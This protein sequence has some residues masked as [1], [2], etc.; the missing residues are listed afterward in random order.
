MFIHYL[1]DKNEVL[2]N[3]IKNG[4]NLI[5]QYNTNSNAGPNHAKIGPYSFNI[6]RERV[7]DENSPV[8]FVIPDHAVFNYPNKI[9]NADFENWI[10]ERGI[11][12][13]DNLNSS[14]V[15]PLALND[16]GES[17]QKG[18]LVIADYG[19]GK[20]VYTGLA[21]FREL[22]AGVTGAYRL[23]ANIIALNKNNK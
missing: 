9:T 2:N 1:T 15:T 20:F 10:Q 16:P 6:S 22:P 19:K 17:E 7:T 4:G 5:V 13:A 8:K 18:S 3:Y 14:F 11:Y 21:F 23:L 12:F